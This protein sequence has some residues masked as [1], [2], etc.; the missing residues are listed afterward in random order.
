M[1]MVG[2]RVAA[3]MARDG[4]LPR[5]FEERGGRPPIGS[6]VLQG[7]IA[8][9]LLLSHSVR[10]ALT[11]VGAILVLFTALTVACLFRV[12]P[13]PT[14][15]VLAAAAVY[16]AA[17]AWML[18]YGFRDHPSLAIWAGVVAIVALAAY[19]LLRVRRASLDESSG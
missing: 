19:A 14:V 10:E 1:M 8:L 11:N 12:R 3:A 13:R 18:F 17:S 9:L 6:V 5:A 16:T 2:P 4:L 15:G 7:G